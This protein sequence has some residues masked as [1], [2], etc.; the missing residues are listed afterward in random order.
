MCIRVFVYRYVSSSKGVIG[1]VFRTCQRRLGENWLGEHPT[2][3][4]GKV[5]YGLNALPNTPV[6]FGTTSIQAPDTSV[7]S[8]RPQY[9]Y[10][11]LR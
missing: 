8:I 11:T 4:F 6:R 7:S 5:R 1:R 9:Y 10:P 2:E 3:A